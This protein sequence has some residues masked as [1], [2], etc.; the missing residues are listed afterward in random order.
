M[1]KHCLRWFLVTATAGIGVKTYLKELVTVGFR[2]VVLVIGETAFLAGLA[3]GLMR[4][5]T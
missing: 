1:R 5:L 3:L 4:W 2:P